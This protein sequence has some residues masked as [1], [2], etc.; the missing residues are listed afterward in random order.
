M[1]M[2]FVISFCCPNRSISF[3]SLRISRMI[4]NLAQDNPT[5]E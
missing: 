2:A 5:F 1:S 3:I 4:G